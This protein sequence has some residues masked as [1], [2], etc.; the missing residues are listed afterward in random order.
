MATEKPG[1][2]FEYEVGLLG[3]IRTRLVDG[4]QTSSRA[5]EPSMARTLLKIMSFP[6]TGPFRMG[7]RIG[8]RVGDL[9]L[10]VRRFSKTPQKP[11]EGP[12]PEDP[13]VR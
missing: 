5:E 1:H 9:L 4:P 13:R 10:S 6:V 8:N 11:P 3:Q 2:H 7:E 12:W